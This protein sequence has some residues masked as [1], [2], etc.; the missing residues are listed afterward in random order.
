LDTQTLCLIEPLSCWALNFPL[1]ETTNSLVCAHPF[2]GMCLVVPDMQESKIFGFA[3]FITAFALL[4]LV[5]TASDAR[6]KFRAAI[7]PFRLQSAIFY[8]SAVIGLAPMPII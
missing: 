1:L 7:A 4:V 8:A 6:S 5:Y 2:A 3:E